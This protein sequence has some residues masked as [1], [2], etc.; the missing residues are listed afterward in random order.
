M[1]RRD[2]HGARQVG[3]RV[4][5]IARELKSR[6]VSEYVLTARKWR[7]ARGLTI[8]GMACMLDVNAGFLGAVELGRKPASAELRARIDAF[9]VRWERVPA[10][11]EAVASEV[12]RSKMRY[13]AAAL[14]R[15][16]ARGVNVEAT[17]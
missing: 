9:V 11:Q 1:R 12:H 6:G 10:I 2:G 17:P 14:G 7:R 8:R 3:V 16:R 15:L 13:R 5:Y 4:T